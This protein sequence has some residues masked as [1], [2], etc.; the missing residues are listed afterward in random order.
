[1][2]P[3][4]TKAIVLQA[5]DFTESSKIVYFISPDYGLVKTLAKGARR[6]TSPLRGQ[7]ELF[8][9]GRMVFYPSR[10]SDLHVL[11]QFDLV[12]GYPAATEN[13][14]KAALFYYLAELT[15]SACYG[16]EHGRDLFNLLSGA[17]RSAAAVTRSDLSRFW[18][19]VRFLSEMGVF[20]P[21]EKCSRCGRLLTSR[22]WFL[23]GKTAWVCPECRRPNESAFL[24]AP[25]QSAA[26]RFVDSNPLKKAQK[27][28]I[29][30]RR[31]AGCQRVVRYLVDS[32][33]GRAIK[34][35]RFLEHVAP[36]S[37]GGKA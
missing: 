16:S 6:S 12:D 7:L 25:D 23:P 3:Q 10:T 29:T 1:M 37:G 32:L 34:S 21:L 28:T 26:F 8:N 20:P 11:G 17:L 5:R 18:F 13:L 31:L 22:V 27:L 36:E 15:A 19:E 14:E 2:A 35:R 33:I 4:S 24:L 30:P 9:Y